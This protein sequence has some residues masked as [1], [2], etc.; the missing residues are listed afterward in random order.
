MRNFYSTERLRFKRKIKRIYEGNKER[1]RYGKK[2]LKRLRGLIQGK[3]KISI[4]LIQ[5]SEYIDIPE[6]RR[7]AKSIWK[8]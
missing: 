4:D 8:N 3:H 1:Y 7:I 2:V 5:K 6:L